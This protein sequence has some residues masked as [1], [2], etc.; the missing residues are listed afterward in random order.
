MKIKHKIL[1]PISILLA[2]LS[3]SACDELSSVTYND[4]KYKTGFY[5]LFKDKSW[6]HFYVDGIK[7]I[8]KDPLFTHNKYNFWAVNDFA[9]EFMC[10]DDTRALSW[11][12][13]I[14]V[15]EDKFKEAKAFYHDDNNFDFYIGQVGENGESVLVE[16]ENVKNAI[17][18]AIE[19]LWDVTKTTETTFKGYVYTNFYCIKKSKDGLF[20]D[21]VSGLVK[22][23]NTLYCL[24]YYDGSRDEN[25]IKDLG[26]A[27]K[28]LYTM[29][30]NNNL[31]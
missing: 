21:G 31:L 8:D 24:D 25:H 5:H 20:A 17:N 18:Y 14:Y 6:P 4:I 23:N 26:E 9:F 19:V 29:F 15:A 2:A 27:G 30:V 10:A 12:P 1:A 3:L 7:Y 22:Y 16:D 28:T 13:I 11:S